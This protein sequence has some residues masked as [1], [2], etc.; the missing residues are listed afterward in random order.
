M[1]IASMRGR[2]GADNLGLLPGT[3]TGLPKG[4]FADEAALPSFSS[5]L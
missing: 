4:I 5:G 2:D 1:T 3:E